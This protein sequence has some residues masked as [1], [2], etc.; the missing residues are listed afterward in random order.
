MRSPADQQCE[1]VTHDDLFWGIN[2][3]I[4]REDKIICGRG[5]RE[6]NCPIVSE[7]CGPEEN[8]KEENTV[9]DSPEDA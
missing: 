2:R 3:V 1:E 9:D 8:G 4:G 6:R 7:N 5:E